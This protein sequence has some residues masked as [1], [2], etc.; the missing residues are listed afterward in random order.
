MSHS[1]EIIQIFEKLQKVY[2]LMPI[3]YFN[4]IKTLF[5]IVQH[6][7]EQKNN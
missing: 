7:Q 2:V 3:K 4:T 6:L 5:H 1:I